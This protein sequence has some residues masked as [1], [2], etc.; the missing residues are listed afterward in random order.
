MQSFWTQNV[1]Y[2]EK[3]VLFSFDLNDCGLS[4][5]KIN[6]TCETLLDFFELFF[7]SRLLEMIVDETNRFHRNSARKAQNHAAPWIDTTTNE[8]YTFLGTVMLMP[9]LKKPYS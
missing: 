9:H 4:S 6:L 5:T 3:I 7:D 8:I 1:T 2:F